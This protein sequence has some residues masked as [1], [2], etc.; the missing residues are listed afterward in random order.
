MSILVNK[1][2]RILV[3]GM[4]GREGTFQTE[5]CIAFGTNIVAGVTPGRGGTA[6]LERPMYDSV[7]EA[8]AAT[9]ANVSLIFV[10]AAFATDAILEAADGGVE[11][12]VCITDGLPTRDMAIATR[13]LKARGV[14]M[15]GPNCPGLT[16]VTDQAKVGIIPGNI[17]LPGRVGVV[18]R[19]GTLTYEAVSQLT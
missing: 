15:I 18:S 10:P 19:S 6:H 16:S 12:I 9:G 1:A 14:R 17:H 3:Q 4:S 8:V 5:R 7:R 13:F 11:L 2:S